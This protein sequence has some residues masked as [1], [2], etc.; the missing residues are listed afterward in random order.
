M[1]LIQIS[2]LNPAGSDLF[3]GTESFLTDL[4]ENDSNSIFGGGKKG[5]GGRG[6]KSGSG[7]GKGSGSGSG[8]GGR[9]GCYGGGGGHYGGGSSS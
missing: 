2:D 1:S 6:R 5:R 7:S 9:G 8:R 4:Q 3:A